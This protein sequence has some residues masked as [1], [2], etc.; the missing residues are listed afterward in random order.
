MKAVVEINLNSPQA[1]SLLGYLES[2]PF[3]SIKKERTKAKSA[4]QQAIDEGGMTPEEFGLRLE[5]R[6]HQAYRP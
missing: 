1:V 4:L 3:A 5:E 6:I 2:L